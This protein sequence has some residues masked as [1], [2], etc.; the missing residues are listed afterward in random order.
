VIPL[1]SSGQQKT[2]DSIAVRGWRV[3]ALSWIPDSGGDAPGEYSQFKSDHGHDNMRVKA[4]ASN[5]P[6]K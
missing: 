3:L 2:L 4:S 6:A 1:M 5:R